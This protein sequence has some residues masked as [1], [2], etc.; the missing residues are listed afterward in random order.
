MDQKFGLM[1]HWGLYNQMGIKESWPL[2][3]KPWTKWQFKPGTTNREVK[4][5]Y[6][7][8]HRGFLPLRFDPDEWAEAAYAAGFRYL[9]FTTKHHDGFCMWDTKCTDYNIMNTP[10][11][12]DILKEIAESCE[13]HGV[14]L[15]LY[16]SIPDWNHKNSLNLGREYHQLKQPN[17]GDE[18]NEELYIQYIKNQMR[19]L[20]TNY[21]R[22]HAIR[23]GAV[24]SFG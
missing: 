24:S 8:L 1:V 2:V 16:Y 11:G 5:M 4:E 9:C 7:Q 13:K 19:E 3:D 23:S 12:R 15:E 18:P 6:A 14:L 17:P 21:G 22:I 10:F 20:C